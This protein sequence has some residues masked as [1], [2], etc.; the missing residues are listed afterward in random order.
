[1]ATETLEWLLKLDAEIDGALQMVRT[2]TKAEQGLHAV[3]V[4][5]GK[6]EK[7]TRRAGEGHGKHAKDAEHL[8]GALHRLVHAGMEPFLER[9]KQ[10]A[11]FEFIRR[12]VDAILEAPSELIEKVKELGEEIL[13]A[14]GKAEETQVIFDALFGNEE[15]KKMAEY[16][17]DLSAKTGILDDQW[18]SIELTLGNAGF[19][20]EDMRRAAAAVSDLGALSGHGAAG[21]EE[22]ADMMARLQNRGELSPRMLMQF[23]ISEK[24]FWKELNERTGVG[25]ETLKKN[26]E[27]G[28]VDI[29]AVKESI[30]SLITAKTHRDL[31]GLGADIGE[32]LNSKWARIKNLP[33][34]FYEQFAESNGYETLK[35]KLD[36]IFEAFDPNGQRGTA[37]FASLESAVTS[38]VEI[39]SEIDFDHVANVVTND[40][41]PAIVKVIGELSDFDWAGGAEMLLDVVSKV[42]EVVDA[43]LQTFRGIGVAATGVKALAEVANPANLL[44]TGTHALLHPV[45]FIQHLGDKGGALENVMKVGRGTIDFLERPLYGFGEQAASGLAK[46]MTAGTAAVKAATADVGYSSMSAMQ[47]TLQ[48]HSPS[49]IFA[50][51]GEMAAAG[52]AEGMTSSRGAVQGA[53][54][55]MVAVPASGPRGGAMTVSMGGINITVAV[56]G[57]G[58]DSR[59]AADEFAARLE[60]I[61]PEH[62]AKL[63]ERVQTMR[64]S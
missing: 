43:I 47:S 54:E 7:A 41:L 26:M 44:K 48:I 61:L 37:I 12:G 60:E 55:S 64:A 2:L 13:I 25:I 30:Y 16:A 34:Q 4:A 58:G 36:E 40:V 24:D 53:T 3:E 27:K 6:A 57:H 62:V 22:A 46:G 9:A 8:E 45:D 31:G 21:A 29:G 20:L 39:V 15:G 52:Y 18:K 38:V 42:K 10:I 5:S 28:K 11:E 32:D 19:K 17:D 63:L 49:R 51:Y 14:A 59:A 33:E 1:M 23:K 56:G 35:S 50:A